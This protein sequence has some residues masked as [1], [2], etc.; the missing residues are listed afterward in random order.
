MTTS[1]EAQQ[2]PF[3]NAR[4]V[5]LLIFMTM[6]LSG[7]WAVLS[8]LLELTPGPGASYVA[9]LVI[10]A[11]SAVLLVAT[12]ESSRI[13]NRHLDSR[14]AKRGWTEASAVACFVLAVSWLICHVWPWT[15]FQAP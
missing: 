1:R 9:A 2:V 5:Q 8:A 7:A 4:R 11:V 10:C 14:L 6:L 13:G 12:R 15:G 3:V